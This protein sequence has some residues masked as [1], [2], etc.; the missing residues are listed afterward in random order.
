MSNRKTRWT[1]SLLPDGRGI[2]ST[3]EL[4]APQDMD[5]ARRVFEQWRD[6]QEP[7]L[8]TIG[9][10]KVRLVENIELELPDA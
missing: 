10:C 5:V 8:L 1:L 4:L 2:L 7:G 9:D 3:E 6:S